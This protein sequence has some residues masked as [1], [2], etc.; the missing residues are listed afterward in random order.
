M[1]PARI[2]DF[3][4]VAAG[5]AHPRVEFAA[6]DRWPALSADVP[7]SGALRNRMGSRWG[8]DG[9]LRLRVAVFPATQAMARSADR[10]A[11][12]RARQADLDDQRNHKSSIARA[13]SRTTERRRQSAAAT[14]LHGEAQQRL[15]GPRM[16]PHLP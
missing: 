11:P 15:D 7:E 3:G 13:A 6:E 9:L 10:F 12:T 2:G 4:P 1:V 5:C 14:R 8:G 16:R